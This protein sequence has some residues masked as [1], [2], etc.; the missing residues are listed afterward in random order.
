[1][2]TKKRATATA[3]PK[4][5]SNA[6]AKARGVAMRR[7]IE[8]YP[9]AWKE[10]LTEERLRLGLSPETGKQ[11]RLQKLVGRMM[12]EGVE[13]DAINEALAEAGFKARV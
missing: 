10:F 12:G 8:A 9:E 5:S 6:G 4:N 7:L 1:M 2:P 11:T 3:A 13:R